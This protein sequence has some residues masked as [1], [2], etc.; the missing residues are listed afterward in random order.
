MKSECY[1]H[2]RDY[3]LICSA[4]H[5]HEQT[6]TYYG[7]LHRDLDVSEGN[8]DQPFGGSLHTFDCSSF[9]KEAILQMRVQQ[10]RRN[11]GSSSNV[12]H[13]NDIEQT[14]TNSEDSQGEVEGLCDAT[15]PISREHGRS[16]SV[17]QDAQE[18]TEELKERTVK[19]SWSGN[20]FS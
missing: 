13:P 6:Y 7:I 15:P 14:E 8:D 20:G 5:V 9:Y 16:T 1:R 12:S 11:S 18:A 19:L 2:Q 4:E 10:R 3:F 17:A